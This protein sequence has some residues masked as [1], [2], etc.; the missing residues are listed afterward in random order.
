M[1]RSVTC[2]YSG[3][4]VASIHLT[5]PRKHQAIN[6]S[7]GPKEHD[8]KIEEL[9]SLT[10]LLAKLVEHYGQALLEGGLDPERLPAVLSQA[11]YALASRFVNDLARAV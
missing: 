5:A 7:M 6:P 9:S 3:G 4:G 2:L 11:K 1:L 10:P 8:M